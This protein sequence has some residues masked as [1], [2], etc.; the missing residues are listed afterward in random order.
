MREELTNIQ[1]FHRTFCPIKTMTLEAQL[2][3]DIEATGRSGGDTLAV[4][5]GDEK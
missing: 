2:F 3:N 4:G 5:M 1:T